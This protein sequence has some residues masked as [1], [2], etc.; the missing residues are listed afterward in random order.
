MANLKIKQIYQK[1]GFVYLKGNIGGYVT[2]FRLVYFG[3][4]FFVVY[5]YGGND[6]YGNEY[7]EYNFEISYDN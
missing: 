7:N 4:D 5:Y 2:D 6:G 3:P 1:D